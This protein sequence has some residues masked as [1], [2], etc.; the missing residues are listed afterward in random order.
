MIDQDFSLEIEKLQEKLRAHYEKKYSENNEIKIHDTNATATGDDLLI[1][2]P[3]RHSK[4]AIAEPSSPNLQNEQPFELKQSKPNNSNLSTKVDQANSIK[5]LEQYVSQNNLGE[6]N[7]E[8]VSIEVKSGG[9]GNK[10]KK[11]TKFVSSV[12]VGEESFQTFPNF[13]HTEEQAEKAAY[14]EN[15][16]LRVVQITSL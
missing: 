1:R 5:L 4:I 7:F 3:Q 14:A 13:F 6:L 12:E 9:N 10:G 11:I 8:T 2:S 15:G 16:E